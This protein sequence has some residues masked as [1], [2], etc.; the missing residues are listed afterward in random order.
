MEN[1]SEILAAA[2]GGGVAMALIV[3]FSLLAIFVAIERALAVWGLADSSRKLSDTVIKCLYRGAVG[4]A[5]AACER[6]GTPFADILL[7]A[8]GRH[9]RSSP[10]NVLAAVERERAQVALRLRSRLWILGTIGATAPFVGLFGTVVGIM[11][12]F[13]DMAAHPG[14]GFAVVAGGIS[15]ALVATAAGIGVAIEAVVLFNYF[16]AR[17]AAL[18]ISF[19]V[20]AEEV[21]DLLFHPRAADSAEAAQPQARLAA[22]ARE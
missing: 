3:L 16:T 14:G 19:K 1:F 11:R 9:G 22:E 12:A 15:E 13:K 8:F 21:V 17:I 5:R 18:L 6:S 20:S 4:D 10:E 2:K 7:A